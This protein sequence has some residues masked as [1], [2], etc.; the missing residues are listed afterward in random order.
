[1]LPVVSV[2]GNS[3]SGK[4]TFLKELIP[5][6]KARG[7]KIATIKHGSHDFEIDKP[8]EDSWQHREV[9]AQ[10]VILSSP[11]KMAMVKELN[12]EIDLDTLIQDYINK[13]IDLVITEG[14][15]GGNKPKVEIFRSAKFDT[16]LFSEQDDDVLTIITNNEQTDRVF[17]ANQ[18]KKVADLI[19]E[20]VME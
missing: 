2:V 11:V 15:K 1:M 5:E 14:Y 17:S 7:Y 13:D 10:T 18:V 6:M 12:Q 8:G 16:P 3:G 20:T 4:T 9:G 19:E